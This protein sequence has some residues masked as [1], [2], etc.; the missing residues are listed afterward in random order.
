MDARAFYRLTA[1]TEWA[2]PPETYSYSSM[3]QMAACLRQW[4]L[5]RSRYEALQRY[6]ERPSEPADV[7]VLVHEI[8]SQLFRAMA[9]AGYPEIGSDA[10]RAAV[11]KVDIRGT[12]SKRIAEL[13]QRA[14]S[15][16]RA[17]G[18]RIQSTA[19]NIYNKI[20]QAFRQEYMAV[21]R[22]ASTLA[23]GPA[24]SADV[25]TSALS[26][27]E[28]LELS[29]ILSEEEVR[30]PSL[31]LRGFIDL[32]VRRGG[33]TTVL[34]FKTGAPQ[35]QYREQ[36]RLY[37]LMWWRSTGDL[38]ATIELRY[39]A[40]VERWPLTEAELVSAEREVEEKIWR[41]QEGLSAHPAAAKLGPHCSGCGVRQLCDVY[42]ESK[43]NGGGGKGARVD[44]EVVVQS[45][46]NRGGF[47]GREPGGREIAVVCEEDVAA[48]HE[49]FVVGERVRIVNAQ[50]E[51]DGPAVQITRA[52]EVF[53]VG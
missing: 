7:G 44:V 22:Q 2:G 29:G 10:F 15:N 8:L 17:A 26:R 31:P 30:H 24:R 52:A 41:Y 36:L 3:K 21:G 48:M 37:A 50:R 18:F 53:R 6:P 12:A 42:W 51:G 47:I 33:E 46:M 49:P 1:P 25:G 28:V 40:H 19:H 9:I 27:R 14:L 11:A 20:A 32:L 38:P 4:Q 35:P 39:G 43:A 34:D 16:P 23:L 45:V 5:G 13:D